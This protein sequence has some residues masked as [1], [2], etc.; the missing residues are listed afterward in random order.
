MQRHLLA[1]LARSVRRSIRMEEGGKVTLSVFVV[2]AETPQ[3][4]RVVFTNGDEAWVPKSQ[5][6]E[7]SDV[8][9]LAD[10]GSLIVPRWLANK[11][12]PYEWD[13]L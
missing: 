13:R 6:S 5:I 3:A 9:C 8:H 12:V 2:L 11:L 1:I 10:E 7:E 4:L